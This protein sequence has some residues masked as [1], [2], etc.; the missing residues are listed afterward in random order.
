MKPAAAKKVALE[1]KQYQQQRKLAVWAHKWLHHARYFFNFRA[2]VRMG[3]NRRVNKPWNSPHEQIILRNRDDAYSS[4]R[5]LD[6]NFRGPRTFISLPG[7][8]DDCWV[9]PEI[10]VK[11][12]LI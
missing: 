3:L 6:I 12:M 10:Y 2:A 9:S 1:F 11:L 7:Q 8:H 4:F 5:L